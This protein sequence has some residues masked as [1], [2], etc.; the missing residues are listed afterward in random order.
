MVI[1][2]GDVLSREL[3]REVKA[4]KVE[5]G[6]TEKETTEAPIA[7]VNEELEISRTQKR[8]PL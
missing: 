4:R 1:S 2:P 8:I 7:S 5:K 3:R 6:R